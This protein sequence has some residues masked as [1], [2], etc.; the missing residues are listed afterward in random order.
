MQLRGVADTLQ[1]L[2][3]DD[4]QSDFVPFSRTNPLEEGNKGSPKIS[5][6]KQHTIH[7]IVSPDDGDDDAST[8]DENYDIASLTSSIEDQLT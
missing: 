7:H 1:P 6:S 2:S 4:L 8:V 5:R 3:M